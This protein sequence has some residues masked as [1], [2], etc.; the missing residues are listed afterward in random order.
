VL[1]LE[2]GANLVPVPA[3]LA[4]LRRGEA[5]ECR[6]GHAATDVHIKAA[7]F[8]LAEG[9]VAEIAAIII[10]FPTTPPVPR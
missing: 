5:K 8:R 1:P 6:L 2:V 3:L 10:R 7:H 9:F 4:H